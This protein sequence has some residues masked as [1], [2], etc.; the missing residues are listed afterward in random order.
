METSLLNILGKYFGGSIT[1]DE[2]TILSKWIEE[3][4]ENKQEFLTMYRIWNSCEFN[5]FRDNLD[6]DKE[7][8]IFRDK[9]QKSKSRKRLNR[10]RTTFISFLSTACVAIIIALV[11]NQDK[12]N[13]SI[14][15]KSNDIMSFVN[16]ATPDF[17]TSKDIQLILSKDKKVD[18]DTESADI[19]YKDDRI[20][21]SDS[22][23]ID[24]NQS[25]NFNQLLIPY[26]KRSTITFSDGT[27]VWANAGTQLVYPIE[28]SKKEREIFVDGQIY[29]DV[30]RDPNRPFIVKTKEMDIEVL[31]TKFNITAYSSENDNNIVLVSGKVSVLNRKTNN[32]TTLTPNKM[33]V[34][35]KSSLNE[36]IKDVDASLYTSWID[37]KYIFNKETF[38]HVLTRLSM[39]YGVKID[40]EKKAGEY[41]CSGKLNLR[42]EFDVVLDGLTN[43]IPISYTF[44]NG[45]YKIK[46]LK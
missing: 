28:F 15:N 27:K 11:L 19:Q 32:N 5:K 12:L 1:E 43:S 8:K 14:L 46:L 39:Y 42:D 45:A 22:K 44:E 21:M 23:N 29:L 37:G 26:G 36:I 40:C 31:G 2:L 18:I 17:T 6:I 41:L 7:L 33:Y 38:E 20:T 10:K 30:A 25:S 13:L 9:A 34:Y 4:E 16:T 3:S 24:K 35:N